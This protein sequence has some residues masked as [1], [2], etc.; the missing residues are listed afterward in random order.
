MV[1]LLGNRFWHRKDA[2]MDLFKHC[3]LAM[4]QQQYPEGQTRSCKSEDAA[5]E[6]VIL[7][8]GS[9]DQSLMTV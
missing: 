7:K 3:P 6:V 2:E 9:G 1:P 5:N 4:L 8:R